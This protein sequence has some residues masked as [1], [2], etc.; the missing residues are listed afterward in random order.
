MIRDVQTYLKERVR[1]VLAGS[2]KPIVIRLQG[3]D[4]EV[5]RAKA[6]EISAAIQPIPGIFD[7]HVENQ[8]E[9]A[10]IQ[11]QVDLN[12]AQRYGLTPGDVRRA[13]STLVSGEEVGDIFRDGKAYDIPVWSPPGERDSVEDIRNLMLDTP[14]GGQVR[15]ADVASVAVKPTPNVLKHEN[16]FRKIDVD[17]GVTGRDLGSVV[18]DVEAALDKVD[19][20]REYHISMLGDY[21]ERRAANR[22]L[23]NFAIFAAIGI[24]VLLQASFLSSRLALLAF[25]TLPMAVVGGMLA[26]YLGDGIIS[27]GSMVGFLAVIGIVAR[28]GIMLIDHYQHLEDE[29]GVPFGPGLVLQGA[30]ERVVPIMMTVLTTGLV[31]VP[32]ILKGSI[33]GHEIE[34]PMAVVIFGGLVTS[35]LLN[36]F[37][38][39]SLYLRFA[40]SRRAVSAV[41]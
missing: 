34:H 10:Q 29:E 16:L 41:S 36:L 8:A 12:T 3:P 40:K 39:P 5:L 33:P 24:F 13:A 21:Q 7:A 32:L 27:L 11:V 35:T 31:L 30:K 26:A 20:P 6:K 14:I 4:L 15:L 9:M 19:L 25:L 18:G 28:N 22:T 23:Q 2:S 1:E 38:V 37:V 17:A